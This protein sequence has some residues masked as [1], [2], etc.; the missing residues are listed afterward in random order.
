VDESFVV[1]VCLVDV[2]PFWMSKRDKQSVDN[3]EFD[4]L[5]YHV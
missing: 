5:E 4:L 3:E 1:I 2:V